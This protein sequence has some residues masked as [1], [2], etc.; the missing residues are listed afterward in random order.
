MNLLQLLIEEEKTFNN[1]KQKLEEKKVIVKEQSDSDLFLAT[2]PNTTAQTD[3]DVD[4]N[5][6][7]VKACKGVIFQRDP[8]KIVCYT[9]SKPTEI[10]LN[11]EKHGV[12]GDENE[13]KDKERVDEKEDKHE[14]E[15][16]NENEKEDKHG[17][18][19]KV[20]RYLELSKKWNEFNVEE[21]IDGSCIKLYYH[22]EMWNISTNRCIDSKKAN[23]NNYKNFY[24]MWEDARKEMELEYDVLDNDCVYSFVLCH[25]Q[26]RIVTKHVKPCII[27][28]GTFN[29]KE[30]KEVERKLNIQKNLTP[31]EYKISSYDEMLS[32]VQK[33][34][35]M[36]RGFAIT[37]KELNENGEYDRYIVENPEFTMVKNVRGSKRSM[38]ERYVEL[39]RTD[40]EMFKMFNQYFPEFSWVDEKMEQLAQMIFWIYTNFYIHKT[41]KFVN[42]KYWKIVNELHNLYLS[43]F[44]K[45]SIHTV[46][47]HLNTYPLKELCSLLRGRYVFKTE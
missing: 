7:I 19:G 9:F 33:L 43:T 30:C 46:R 12:D 41:T 14:D 25:P 10:D 31:K 32:E 6:P 47:N 35:Y 27:H 2:Y 28:I 15:K 42:P 17:D 13:D 39:S 5:D 36:T 16:E 22:N 38:I 18:D 29:M 11:G 26:N 21:L 3:T 45:T 23:W 40:S 1:F 44:E 8:L 20:N 4:M 34:H 24:D 37:S